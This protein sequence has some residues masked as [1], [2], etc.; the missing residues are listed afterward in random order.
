VWLAKRLEVTP[1]VVNLWVKGKSNPSDKNK[2][3]IAG[4]LGISVG[5]LFFDENGGKRG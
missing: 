5:E 2:V 4:L 1:Q 3:R